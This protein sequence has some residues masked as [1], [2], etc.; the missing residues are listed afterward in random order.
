MANKKVPK[1]IKE[2]VFGYVDVDDIASFT[3]YERKW[4][5]KIKKWKEEYPDKVRII[6]ENAD[7][8]MCAHL[9]KQWFKVSPPKKISE[10]HRARMSELGKSM[11]DKRKQDNSNT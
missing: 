8:T 4:I 10:E 7:G 6:A 3:T 1:E 5:N 2:T 9:P 11:A